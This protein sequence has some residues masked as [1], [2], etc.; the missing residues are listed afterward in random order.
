MSAL[1]GGPAARI[2]QRVLEIERV[3]ENEE[4]NGE[5]SGQKNANW[6]KQQSEH[7]RRKEREN[8]RQFDD[9]GLN[10]GGY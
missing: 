8:W 4:D 7:Q 6:S 3:Y 9:F 5:R 1:G 2:T 10:D